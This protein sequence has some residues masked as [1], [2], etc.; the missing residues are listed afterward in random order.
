[1]TWAVMGCSIVYEGF[2]SQIDNRTRLDMWGIQLLPTLDSMLLAWALF[3]H[4]FDFRIYCL[5][6]KYGCFFL[7]NSLKTQQTQVGNACLAYIHNWR[8]KNTFYRASSFIKCCAQPLSK[9]KKT[10]KERFFDV[11][12]NIMLNIHGATVGSIFSYV[13]TSWL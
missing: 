6:H 10:M 12:K 2:W 11:C 4:H 5:L 7:T 8:A 13:T 3:C 1:M 9:W